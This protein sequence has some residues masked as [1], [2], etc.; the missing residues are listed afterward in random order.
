MALG[1]G[2]EEGEIVLKQGSKVPGTQ[3]VFLGLV[4]VIPGYAANCF[5]CKLKWIADKI[6]RQVKHQIN[7]TFMAHS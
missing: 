2:G 5:S 1:V 7:R 4:R 3:K 6:F